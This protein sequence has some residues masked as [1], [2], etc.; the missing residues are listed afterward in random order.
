VG[1]AAERLQ[2]KMGK[3]KEITQRVERMFRKVSNQSVISKMLSEECRPD[4]QLDRGVYYS[5]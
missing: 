5:T 1:Y 3:G 4:T 2:R